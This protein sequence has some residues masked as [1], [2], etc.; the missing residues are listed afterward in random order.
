[1]SPEQVRAQPVDQRTDIFSLGIVLYE[2]LAGTRPFTGGSAVET[3]NAILTVDPPEMAIAGRAVPAGLAGIVR[4]CLEKN[5]EE[6][7]QSARD[8]GF[9][10]QALSGSAA[11]GPAS[12]ITIA[13][14]GKG[15][16]RLGGVA[17]LLLASLGGAGVAIGFWPRPTAPD[18]SA[19]TFTPFATDPE[20]EDFPAW[21][22]D[23]RSLA[24]ARDARIFVR[25]L[26][27]D[28]AAPVTQGRVPVSGIFWFPDNTSSVASVWRWQASACSRRSSPA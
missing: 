8:L 4:H 28:D 22:P 20:P 2:M 12:S 15:W 27:G 18:L 23:G 17:A 9:A 10:L 19:F 24:Y 3:M 1:M 25:S 7:F 26:D 11:S 5:P 13:S 14:G 6:R 21:S 16:R